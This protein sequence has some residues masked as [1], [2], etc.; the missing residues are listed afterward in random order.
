MGNEYRRS[1]G[2]AGRGNDTIYLPSSFTGDAAS[3]V[4]VRGGLGDDA[5]IS[6]ALADTVGGFIA[7][8]YGDEGNDKI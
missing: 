6:E 4:I 1:T 7:K 3:A 5:F 2:Y 8:L